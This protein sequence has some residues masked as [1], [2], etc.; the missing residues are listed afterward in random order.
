MALYCDDR[1]VNS[2]EVED[3]AEEDFYGYGSN[4][5]II[6]GRKHTLAGAS[7]QVGECLMDDRSD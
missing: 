6:Y 5:H 1:S 2:E 3:D 7:E 4:S